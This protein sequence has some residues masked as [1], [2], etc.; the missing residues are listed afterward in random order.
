MAS[1]TSVPS[2]TLPKTSR[3]RQLGASAGQHDEELAAVGVGAGVG[4]GDGVVHVRARSPG[5]LVG[6]LVAEVV[7]ARPGSP[8]PSPAWMTKPGT[9][10]WNGTPS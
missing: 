8:S 10:R 3:R 1:I 4:H 9:T 7:G 5:Q 6:E 2:V